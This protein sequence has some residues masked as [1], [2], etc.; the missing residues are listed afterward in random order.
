[1]P[2]QAPYG[3]LP[4]PRKGERAA[5]AY[6]LVI[7]ADVAARQPGYGLCAEIAPAAGR[8]T[9]NHNN[10]AGRGAARHGRAEMLAQSLRIVRRS[11]EVQAARAQRGGQT[12]EKQG[13]GI[14]LAGGKT[15]L[16]GRTAKFVTSGK[17]S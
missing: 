17:N 4:H 7:P 6:P 11:A 15:A 16:R 8:T 13:I 3:C 5:A 1:M 12:P 2:R 10:V 9:N 14:A